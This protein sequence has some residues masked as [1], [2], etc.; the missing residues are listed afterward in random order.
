MKLSIVVLVLIPGSFALI[1]PSFLKARNLG[2][3]QTT[4]LYV[5]TTGSDSNAGT[6]NAPLLSIQKAVDLA[7]PGTT[8]YIRGGTYSPTTNIK[9]AKSGTSSAPYTIRNYGTEKVI[10]DGEALP[11]TPA[12]LGAALANP[13]RGVFHLQPADYWR[14]IGLE[15][16]NGPYGVYARDSSNNIY[17]NLI[18]HDNY[19][20]GLQIQGSASNNQVINLDS[21]RN[22]DPRKNGESADGLAIKEGSGTGNI[23]RGARLWDNVDDGLDFI[24]FTSPITVEDS[25]AWGN[26]VNRWGF[27]DFGGDGNGFKLGGGN[28]LTAVPHIVKNCMAFGNAHGGFIDNTQRGAHTV[29]RNTAWA[30]GESGFDFAD[31]TPTI[32]YNIAVS[33]NPNTKLSG[34]TKT[35]NSWQSGTWSNSSFISTDSSILKGPRN[36]NGT[37]KGSNFLIPTSRAAIGATTWV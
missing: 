33:N 28:N 26:G 34:G 8:I 17:E 14:L 1:L 22:R 7:T 6:L 15:I 12:A 32:S 36:A 31:S 3:R 9:I 10:V 11:G 27:S 25:Y 35:G 37:V 20:S 2:A 19:E 5:A 13:D 18:T 4:S 29:Y 24:M 30:N 21:Y 23:V 16:I